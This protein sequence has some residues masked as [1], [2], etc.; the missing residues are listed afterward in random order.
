MTQRD[1]G[2]QFLAADDTAV[3]I[4]R[5]IAAALIGL[6]GVRV[7]AQEGETRTLDQIRADVIADLLIEGRTDL[8]PAEAR[9][10]RATVAVTVPVLALLE[11]AHEG[12]EPAVVEGVGPIPVERARELAG[13]AEGWMRVLTHP[14]TGMVLS[15]GRDRFAPTESAQTGQVASRPLHGT[16]MRDAG[17]PLR[18][19]PSHRM[20]ARGRDPA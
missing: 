15:V 2:E 3:S 18:N 9:G 13:G 5:A 19:R 20:G 11:S 12:A 17:I 7:L 6:D 10:I 8:H 1:E 16:R 14:E 4:Y